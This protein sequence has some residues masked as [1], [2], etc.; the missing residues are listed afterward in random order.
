VDEAG[1]QLLAALNADYYSVSGKTAQHFFCPVLYCDEDVPFCKAHIINASFPGADPTWTVQREDVDNH[2]GSVLESEFVKLRHRGKH[3]ALDVLTDPKLAKQLR[4]RF[5]VEGEEVGHFMSEDPA[6]EGFSPILVEGQAGSVRLVLK[7]T[8]EETLSALE[9]DWMVSTETDVRLQAL[10]SLLKAAHLTLFHTMGYQYA[11][12]SGGRF[13]GNEVLGAFYR[14]SVGK[15]RREALDLAQVHFRQFVNLVRPAPSAPSELL[16]TITD[17]LLYLCMHGGAPW[18]I[19][20]L[21]R[22]A[23][24]MSVVLVPVFE[25]VEAS[26]RFVRF[27]KE[28]SSPFEVTLAKFAGDHW[29]VSPQSN[30]FHWPEANLE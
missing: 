9:K 14:A 17:S 26:A 11:L 18:A 6:P 12:S 23:D 8:P 4:P 7:M 22:T 20:V 24:F 5:Q 13:M 28:P 15:S 10:G 30:R 2:F 25:E 3:R 21:V 16:G 19:A 1:L 27:L 29:D